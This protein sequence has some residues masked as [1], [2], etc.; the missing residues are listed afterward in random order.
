MS[1]I[2]GLLFALPLGLAG[3]AVIGLAT[4]FLFHQIGN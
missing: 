3:W 2:R 1:A 4:C